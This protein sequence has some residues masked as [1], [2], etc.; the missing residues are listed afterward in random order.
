M[1]NAEILYGWSNSRV[2]KQ[3][4]NL[5]IVKKNANEN[6]SGFKK[7]LDPLHFSDFVMLQLNAYALNI[8]FP[9]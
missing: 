7:Y 6:Y 5:L 1:A 8:F 3:N 2:G 4:S 9:P